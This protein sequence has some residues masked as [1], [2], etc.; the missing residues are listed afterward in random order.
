MLQ[1]T[2][3]ALMPN[4]QCSCRL[5]SIKIIRFQRHPAP[6]RN[7]DL[8]ASGK[9]AG[10]SEGSVWTRSIIY[11]SQLPLESA[12]DQIVR[13]LCTPLHV[14]PRHMWE[15]QLLFQVPLPIASHPDAYDKATLFDPGGF[16]LDRYHT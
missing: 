3:I 6:S 5:Y 10:F 11:L 14:S 12:D 4:I 15:E 16:L 7:L 8:Q 13:S 9:I 1:Y 2:K